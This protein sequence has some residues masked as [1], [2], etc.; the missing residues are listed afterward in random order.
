[1][2]RR[3]GDGTVEAKLWIRY[4]KRSTQLAESSLLGLFYGTSGRERERD[5]TSPLCYDATNFESDVGTHIFW[6]QCT[7]YE[8]G[9]LLVV[10]PSVQVCTSRASVTDIQWFPSMSQRHRSGAGTDIFV[11]GCTDGKYLTHFLQIWQGLSELCVDVG[12]PYPS[13]LRVNLLCSS[14]L[15]LILTLWIWETCNP[16][17]I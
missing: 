17:C 4:Q 6:G 7:S 5:S 1:M 13:L 11:V 16:C 15:R 10:S 8:V 2:I 12:L 14:M 9:F 3:Y